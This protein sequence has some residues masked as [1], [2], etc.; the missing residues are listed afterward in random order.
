MNMQVQAAPTEAAPRPSEIQGV[1]DNIAAGRVFGWAWNPSEPAERVTIELRLGQ[2]IVAQTLAAHERAD[3]KGAGIGDGCHA[4]ELRLTPELIER[5]AEIF[6]VARAADGLEVPL[7]ILG[8]RRPVAV[9]PGAPGAPPAQA[10]ARSVQSIAG[11]Q[12]ALSERLAALAGRVPEATAAT[13]DLAAR[14]ATLEIWC[15]RIDER[16]AAQSEPG[17]PAI[18]GRRLDAWQIVLVGLAVAAVTGSVALAWIGVFP[19]GTAG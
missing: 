4:F 7:P 12:R 2:Q 17:L 8:A 9:V 19:S 11:A 6:I 3:L 1:V 10:L 5:R 14:I 13:A 15:L 18:P 16:L